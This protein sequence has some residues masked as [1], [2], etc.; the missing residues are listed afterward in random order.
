[1]A[2]VDVG[3]VLINMYAQSGCKADAR[4]AFDHID[5]HFVLSLY[6]QF[7]HREVLQ[8]LWLL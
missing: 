6:K 4:K 3:N 8:K 1:M 7:P 5:D 2:R